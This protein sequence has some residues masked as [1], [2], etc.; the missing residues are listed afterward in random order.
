MLPLRYMSVLHFYCSNKMNWY[1]ICKRRYKLTP[2]PH[3]ES[4][5]SRCFCDI[6]SGALK[7]Q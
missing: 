7:V 1:R 2:V 5:I 3:N 6:G 4:K